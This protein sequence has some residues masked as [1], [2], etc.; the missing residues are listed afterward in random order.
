MS[1]CTRVRMVLL[2]CICLVWL[3]NGLLQAQSNDGSSSS[4]SL[5]EL[6]IRFQNGTADADEVN[7]ITGVVFD[8]EKYRASQESG[9]RKSLIEELEEHGT[10]FQ[11]MEK[12]HRIQLNKPVSSPMILVVY[13][14]GIYQK[15]LEGNKSEQTVDMTVYEPT[16]NRNSLRLQRH[17]IPIQRREDK[18]QVSEI[19][20]F[21]NTGD[22]TYV[23]P[24]GFEQS[25]PVTLPDKANHVQGARPDSEGDANRKSN[26][27]WL[28]KTVP[29]N[30]AVSAQVTYHLP[31]RSSVTL[32]RKIEYPTETFFFAVGEGG[33]N[34][35]NTSSNLEK[36]S[37]TAPSG[38]RDMIKLTGRNLSAGDTVSVTFE[39]AGPAPSAGSA[40]AG[41]DANSGVSGGGTAGSKA[42]TPGS[43]EGEMNYLFIVVGV[44]AG[45]A[46]IVSLMAVVL[47]YRTRNR[48]GPGGVSEANDAGAPR[49][50]LIEE[51]AQLDQDLEDGNISEEYHRKRR[52]RL[53]SKL[54]SLESDSS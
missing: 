17:H 6:T 40:T 13:K 10:R 30:R 47:M 53:K 52:S 26:R 9:E 36:S 46:L 24:D 43:G 16:R 23:G 4:T 41:S 50:L 1:A 31:F 8:Y 14:G 42:G 19:M 21:Q 35:T 51:I 25:I 2:T 37:R 38:K 49:D 39:P 5:Q 12:T 28:S 29:P 32:E 7:R 3:S 20:I 45:L 44:L 11:T 22:R 27:Y 34:I 18:L 15:K 33:V 54:M 48:Q